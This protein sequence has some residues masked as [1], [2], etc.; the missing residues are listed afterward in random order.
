LARVVPTP[1]AQAYART[2]PQNHV[3]QKIPQSCLPSMF[4]DASA[5]FYIY[6]YLEVLLTSAVPAKHFMQYSLKMKY[7]AGPSIRP[8]VNASLIS[9]NFNSLQNKIYYLASGTGLAL[10]LLY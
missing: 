1:L 3:P 4:S 8:Y 7:L 9:H 5:S 6:R 10:I 2:V